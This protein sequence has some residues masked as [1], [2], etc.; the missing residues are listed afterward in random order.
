[1]GPG[2]SERSL[3]EV[4]F[5]KLQNPYVWIVGCCKDVLLSSIAYPS[6]ESCYYEPGIALIRYP[7]LH[8]PVRVLYL[9]VEHPY[10]YPILVLH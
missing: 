10:V 6:V 5:S 8:A 2:C 7:P 1:M 9:R 4:G 3:T